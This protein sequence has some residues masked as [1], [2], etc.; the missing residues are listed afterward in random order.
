MANSELLIHTYEL[1][2][3][4]WERLLDSGSFEEALALLDGKLGALEDQTED[5]FKLESVFLKMKASTYY[6]VKRYEEAIEQYQKCFD[7][8]K[9]DSH[10]LFIGEC[11][12]LAGDREAA[13][14]TFARITD[15]SLIS[16]VDL[17]RKHPH[18]FLG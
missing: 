4:E 14:I 10:L 15:P 8:F 3:S 13:E 1:V 17:W 9:H 11:Q 18:H 7:L 5:R 6:K 16:V 12:W 2:H